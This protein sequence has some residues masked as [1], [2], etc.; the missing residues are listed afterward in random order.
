LS[1]QYKKIDGEVNYSPL[2][3]ASRTKNIWDNAPDW[4]KWVA[5]DMDGHCYWYENEPILHSYGS[6]WYV[7]SG[8]YLQTDA[9]CPTLEKMSRPEEI[10]QRSVWDNAPDWAKWLVKDS[11]GVCWWYEYEPWLLGVG[12]IDKP[13]WCMESGRYAIALPSPSVAMPTLTKIGRD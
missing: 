3:K 2:T 13:M 4:A 6:L 12:E 7:L 10:K 5:K 11:C 8:N 9:E 1:G